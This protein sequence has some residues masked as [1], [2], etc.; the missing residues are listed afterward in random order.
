MRTWPVVSVPVKAPVELEVVVVK[1]PVAEASL[2]SRGAQ[3]RLDD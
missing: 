2:W 1:T 3:L